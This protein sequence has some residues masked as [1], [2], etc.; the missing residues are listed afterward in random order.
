MTFSIS[1]NIFFCPPQKSHTEVLHSI[2]TA[3]MLIYIYICTVPSVSGVEGIAVILAGWRWTQQ[4]FTVLIHHDVFFS[5]AH[6]TTSTH[7]C[8]SGPSHTNTMRHFTHTLH[9]VCYCTN[10][11][12]TATSSTQTHKLL[13]SAAHDVTH[14]YSHNDMKLVMSA[15]LDT[16]ESHMTSGAVIA[17]KSL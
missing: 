14:S 2:S 5:N 16:C 4:R 17:V 3:E 15:C 8:S 13:N 6:H 7:T 10:T 9:N 1:P 12:I 11:T